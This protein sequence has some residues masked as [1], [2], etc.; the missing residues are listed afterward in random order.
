LKKGYL[1]KNPIGFEES[2]R[3][4][5]KV[6]AGLRKADRKPLKGLLVKMVFLDRYGTMY[7]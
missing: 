2:G 3:R 1:W 4:E 5:T 7:L 6:C